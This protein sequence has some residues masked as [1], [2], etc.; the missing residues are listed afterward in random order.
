MKTQRSVNIHY[1]FTLI[2]LLVVVAVIAILVAIMMPA[3]SRARSQAIQAKCMAVHK[4][5]MACT[6]IYAQENADVFPY[7]A[8]KQ[9]KTDT[10]DAPWYAKQFIGGYMGNSYD[11]NTYL[12]HNSLLST[13]R[14]YFCPAMPVSTAPS[15]PQFYGGNVGIGANVVNQ[16]TE[17]GKNLF[18]YRYFDSSSVA[19]D[20]MPRK[21]SQVVSPSGVIAYADSIGQTYGV[22]YIDPT[23]VSYL[24]RGYYASSNFADKVVSYRHLQR[25]T[26]SF[27][28]G[29]A[30]TFSSNQADAPITN[31]HRNQGLHRAYVN[32]AVT[33]LPY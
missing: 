11:A 29:H 22:A 21:L 3:L 1:G 15:L 19:V 31:T 6:V 20:V 32:H 24:W 5:I 12:G 4:Q 18:S 30:E 26:V 23:A 7:A 14:N 9:N 16:V 25:T 17:G 27:A 33:D 8:W 10:V 2:E 28:D 13:T